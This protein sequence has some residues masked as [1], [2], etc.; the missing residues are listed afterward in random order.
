VVVDA[1]KPAISFMVVFCIFL[2]A[3][4]VELKDTTPGAFGSCNPTDLQVTDFHTNVVTPDL[5]SNATAGCLGCHGTSGGP[6][7][8]SFSYKGSATSLTDKR[9]NYCTI[10]S[11]G[12]IVYEA[13]QSG[14]GQG[15]HVATSASLANIKAF[16]D[17]QFGGN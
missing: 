2:V 11:F 12:Y 17:A 13:P 3:C 1:I 15:G 6:G 4:G 5:D 14:G 8:G 10:R 9:E 7:R 16:L